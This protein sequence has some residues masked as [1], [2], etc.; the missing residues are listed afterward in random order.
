MINRNDSVL[1]RTVCMLSESTRHTGPTCT[2]SSQTLVCNLSVT[3]VPLLVCDFKI[4]II[5][6]ICSLLYDFKLIFRRHLKMC[7][8]RRLNRIC[9]DVS[10]WRRARSDFD[11]VKN[12]DGA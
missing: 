7:H 10:G 4:Y 12:M 8:L 5:R 6:N 9:N 3:S 11:D 2:T 1:F